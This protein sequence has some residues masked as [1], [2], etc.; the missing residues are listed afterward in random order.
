MVD[1][2]NKQIIEEIFNEQNSLESPVN[3]QFINSATSPVNNSNIDTV[4]KIHKPLNNEPKFK[5]KLDLKRIQKDEKDDD[6]IKS[7]IEDSPRKDQKYIS[8]K[9][10]DQL[11]DD[12]LSDIQKPK[13]KSHVS[14]NVPPDKIFNPF[15]GSLNINDISK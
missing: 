12:D 8:F 2:C 13:L 15:L 4:T 6:D 3:M 9:D 7:E 10:V 5:L 1:N 14:L 11:E